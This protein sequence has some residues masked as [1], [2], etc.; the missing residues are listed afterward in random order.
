MR[1][2]SQ[3]RLSA[4]LLP[5]LAESRSSEPS[6][7]LH[8]SQHLRELPANG[9]QRPRQ[10]FDSRN[11]SSIHG[12]NGRAHN[13]AFKTR[14]AGRVCVNASRR[15]LLNCSRRDSAVNAFMQRRPYTPLPS[16]LGKGRKIICYFPFSPLPFFDMLQGANYEASHQ[17]RLESLFQTM[18]T[19]EQKL[20]R[21][22]CAHVFCVELAAAIRGACRPCGSRTDAASYWNCVRWDYTSSPHT[23]GKEAH[24][25]R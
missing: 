4:I 20:Q 17:R 8:P 12:K 15:Q 25:E 11:Y 16:E 13:E 10:P 19:Y 5:F 22:F 3:A 14:S 1:E 23:C 18:G 24:P 7:P 2:I 6:V 9:E 21:C